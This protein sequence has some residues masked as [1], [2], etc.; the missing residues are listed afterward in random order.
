MTHKKDRVAGCLLGGAVGD[1]LGAPVEFM[2]Y[3]AILRYLGPAGLRYTEFG[4]NK[5]HITDDTQ[6]TLF[7]AEGMLAY[8]AMLRQGREAEF[9]ATVYEAFQSWLN[10]QIY[11]T[12]EK[13]EAAEKKGGLWLHSE[14]RKRRAPGMTCLDA[15]G[16]GRP[17]SR[18]LKI[19]DSKGCGGVMRAA[20]A[21]L[22]ATSAEEAYRWGCRQAALTHTHPSG[23][24]SA[25]ALARLVYHLCEGEDIRDALADVLSSVAEEAQGAETIQA[26]SGAM[27]LAGHELAPQKAYRILGEGWVAEEALAI[28]VYA[29]LKAQGSFMKGMEVAVIHNGDSDSTGSIAGNILGAQLGVSSI[30]GVLLEDLQERAIIEKVA[31][32]L[33]D[34]MA[35]RL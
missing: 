20:P 31:S 22:L 26:L 15:L 1:A 27:E 16:A 23:Y 29:A 14:L 8:K 18:T 25:G 30:P 19:N 13:R 10:T 6:M 28:G 4:S 9:D 7:A 12:A 2:A 11:L 24:I 33:V 21:G 34:D 32:A 17:G 35:A 3:E 5:G